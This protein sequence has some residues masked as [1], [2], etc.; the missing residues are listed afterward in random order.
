MPRIIFTGTLPFMPINV[1]A[2]QT[3]EEPQ[4]WVLFLNRGE[5]QAFDGYYAGQK[6]V[7]PEWIRPSTT[8]PNGFRFTDEFFDSDNEAATLSFASVTHHGPSA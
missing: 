5:A 8:H 4:G 1:H 3:N 6:F 2:V 7:R